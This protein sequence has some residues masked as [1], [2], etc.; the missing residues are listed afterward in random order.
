MV[1]VSGRAEAGLVPP[2]HEDAER[3]LLASML[4]TVDARE[5]ALARVDSTD[6]YV[7]AHAELYAAM[8]ALHEQGDAVSDVT[9][10]AWLD[11]HLSPHSVSR[12]YLAELTAE[13]SA[14]GW[15]TYAQLIADAAAKRRVIAQAENLRTAAYDGAADLAEVVQLAEGLA[16]RARFPASVIDAGPDIDTFLAMTDDEPDWVIQGLLE[17]TDRCIVTGWLEGGGKSTLQRQLAVQGAAGLVPF[18]AGIRQDPVRVLIVDCE[19]PEGVVR[20]KIRALRLSA[21]RDLD[22]PSRLVIKCRPEG[23]DLLNLR[24]RQWLAGVIAAN[25]PDLVMLGPLYKL[26]ED[27]PTA[28]RP[29]RSLA[30]YLDRLRIRHGFA[31]IIEAHTPQEVQGFRRPL[32]P[33]GASLWRRWPELGFG[34]QRDEDDD[35][36]VYRLIRWRDERDDRQWPTE[37]SRGGTWPWSRGARPWIPPDERADLI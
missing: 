15:N 28:E 9:V 32:R 30:A 16:E 11:S 36:G 7:P 35:A 22:D 27:D 33:Y 19:N 26:H 25:R 2:Y 12:S 10:L 31:L 37:V 8:V 34:L 4:W 13:P 3:R 17:R 23:L 18:T 6:L 20:R 29:A 1:A 14:T 21:G 5:A 24:D